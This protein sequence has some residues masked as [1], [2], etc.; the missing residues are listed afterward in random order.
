M[1]SGADETATFAVELDSKGTQGPAE[2][3][4]RSLTDLQSKIE[5][6]IAAL[7]NMNKALRNLKGGGDVAKAQLDAL[8]DRITAQKATIA[9]TQSQYIKLGGTFEKLKPQGD[10]AGTGIAG[11]LAK[12]KD[13]KGPLGEY[14]TKFGALSDA[15]GGGVAAAGTLAVAA[16][17]VALTVAIIA[18][19]A[20][21]TSYG[22]ATANAHR[23]E[24]LQL[25]GLTKVRNYY[26]LAAGSA[27]E[28]QKAL[29]SV[30]AG[31]AASREDLL[32]YEK[33]LYQTGLRGNNLT[34]A[35]EGVAITLSAQGSGRADIFAA[36]VAGAARSGVAVKQF[37]D[38]AK[39]RLG[40][41]A[42]AQMLD[43]NVQTKKL[44]E[45]FAALFFGLKIDPVLEGLKGVTD[46]FSQ[47]TET[48]KALKTLVETLF[49]PLVDEVGNS[50]PL[51]K[52]FFQ[53]MV[54]AA[55]D[56]AI[57][58]QKLR[59]WFRAT[60]GDS[61]ILKGFDATTTALA[62]GKIAL[63]AVLAAVTLVGIALGVA[64]VEAAIFLAPW[65]AL[66]A[67]AFAFGYAI[68]YVINYV[69]DIHWGQAASDLVDGFVGGISRGV[70]R[71]VAAVKSMGR[72]AL[73][74]LRHVLDSHSPSKAASKLGI[75]L[76]QGQAE[77]IDEGRHLV[78]AAARRSGQDS[79]DSM[80][81]GSSLDGGNTSP[82]APAG[83]GPVQ[84]TLAPVFN[85]NGEPTEHKKSVR[86]EFMQLLTGVAA[87]IGA[88][89]DPA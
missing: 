45:N 22:I 73:E 2:A 72:A 65:I 63:F 60:F 64:A 33:Q 62:A 71:V 46:L 12:M 57:A 81:I 29:D 78:R 44:H 5:G 66:A 43:L 34:E 23:A 37:T 40:G 82:A 54:L 89:L 8:K 67:A 11:L 79:L 86:D 53:G 74:A 9:S 39:A 21:L 35:L 10:K 85:F 30:S 19:V 69:K 50:G 36:T 31:S 1:A 51:V 58:V 83:R 56:V 84:I 16:A 47:N 25:D 75:T 27:T 70:Q 52:R 14:A 3:A 17:V 15:V 7:A 76:P 18:G 28:M 55:L 4:A 88:S 80:S 26:G 13:S 61:T 77:G 32:G 68:G 42:A 6:D 24:L 20:A 48:G 41:L 49:Q 87:S 59:L 38:D